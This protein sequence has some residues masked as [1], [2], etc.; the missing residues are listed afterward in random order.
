MKILKALKK[1]ERLNTSEIVKR[2][3]SNFKVTVSH[4]KLLEDEG[5]L[6]HSNFGVRSHIYRF[7]D[8]LRAKA[9]F[10]LLEAWEPRK[11]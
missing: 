10:G 7:S 5:I 3:G 4:L 11:D 9:V 8:S 2:V 1:C 6:M